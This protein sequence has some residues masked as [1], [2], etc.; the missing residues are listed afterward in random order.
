M[1]SYVGSSIGY[2]GVPSID[3]RGPTIRI[4]DSIAISAAACDY[5]G[6]K[7]FLKIFF[8]SDSD[9]FWENTLFSAIPIVVSSSDMC[10]KQSIDSHNKSYD[11]MLEQSTEFEL[12]QWGIVRFDYDVID[13]YNSIIRSASAVGLMDS[14]IVIIVMEEISA[15][16]AGQKPIEDVAVIIEDRAQT[17][18]DERY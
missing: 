4:G 14:D 7:E 6:A 15:Y 11:C 8:S 12:A 1:I 16:F 9:R 5:D 18:I 13:D 10:S 17:V 3:G 2:Y